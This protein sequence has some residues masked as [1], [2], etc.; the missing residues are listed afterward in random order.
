MM[1]ALLLVCQVHPWAGQILPT[2]VMQRL[3]AP[4]SFPWP[5]QAA[6]IA[7]ASS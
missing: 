6:V 2:A 7:A 4:Y 1:A 5:R 3:R